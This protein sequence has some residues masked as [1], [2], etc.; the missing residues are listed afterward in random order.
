M[1]NLSL[2]IILTWTIVLLAGCPDSGSKY[3]SA[4]KKEITTVPPA[5][6]VTKY[7]N[8][9]NNQVV[10]NSQ[11]CS[12]LNSN[13]NYFYSFMK[14][15]YDKSTYS[16]LLEHMG[17]CTTFNGW[18]KT[19]NG[20]NVFYQYQQNS[21]TTNCSWWSQQPMGIWLGFFQGYPQSVSIA[22]D[23]TG[24]GWASGGGQGFPVRRFELNG[25]ID[26]SKEDLTIWA[27]TPYGTWLNIVV[28]K[29]YGNKN[30]LD[31]RA[32]IYFNGKQIGKT[33]LRRN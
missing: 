29:E 15:V 12:S 7:E 20:N 18:I 24:N 5:D 9:D 1:K 6:I 16:Q 3:S 30:A 11:H 23:A 10:Y 26:C 28:P 22:I 14:N 19:V 25:T 32:T 8:P 4:N 33:F 13:A 31:M 2:Y 27:Q 21:G 17:G